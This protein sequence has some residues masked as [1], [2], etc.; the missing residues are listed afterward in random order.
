MSGL[1]EAE[2]S[3][4]EYEVGLVFTRRKRNKE[5]HI[6]QPHDPEIVMC[7]SKRISLGVLLRSLEHFKYYRVMGNG[8]RWVTD[9][10][11]EDCFIPVCE[12]CWDEL[13]KIKRIPGYFEHR[14]RDASA[15]L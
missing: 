12:S 8:E 5:L 10:T 2:L 1:W 9:I 14:R 13:L 3:I 6:V 15:S 11:I 4:K 7:G